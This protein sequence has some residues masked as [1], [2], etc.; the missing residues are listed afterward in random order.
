MNRSAVDLILLCGERY[1]TDDKCLGRWWSEQLT[2]DPWAAFR[3]FLGRAM[4]Q[5]RSD[6]VSERVEQRAVETLDAFWT[7]EGFNLGLHESAIREALLSRIGPR[8]VGK[9]RDVDMVMSALDFVDR[10]PEWAN[11]NIANYSI[12]RI[13]AGD[14]SSHYRELQRSESSG[15]IIQVGPKI[16]AFYLRDIVSLYGLE[17]AVGPAGAACLQPVDTWVR[18][19]AEKLEIARPRAG[20]DEVKQSIVDLCAQC[21]CSSALFNQGIWYLATHARDLLLDG[22]EQV[23]LSA[24]SVWLRFPRDAD[25]GS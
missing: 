18:R 19:I 16:A 10:L 23:D 8:K 17:D 24:G 9:V 14:T 12:E 21:G 25:P 3:F 6:D 4:Y 13:K 11:R 7:D 22:V 20:D 1:R 2:D 15:G 5:G